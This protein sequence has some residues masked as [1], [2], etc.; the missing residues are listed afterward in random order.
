MH[1]LLSGPVPV[2]FD[3][4][5]KV[6]KITGN[7]IPITNTVIFIDKPQRTASSL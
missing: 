3:T 2:T 7:Y 4:R 5:K 6:T 1:V